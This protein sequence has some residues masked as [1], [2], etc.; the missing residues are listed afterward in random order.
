MR[1]TYD[2][3][4][5]S[6]NDRIE[7]I[8]FFNCPDCGVKHSTETAVIRSIQ[9]KSKYLRTEIKGKIITRLYLDT[10]YKVRFCHK[11][12]RKRSIKTKIYYSFFLLIIP[13]VSSSIVATS[14][15]HFFGAFIGS[16][17]LSW[18]PLGLTNLIIMGTEIDIDHAAQ[19][20]A[21]ESNKIL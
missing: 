16:F 6:I 12:A 15:G 21:L 18:V 8:K 9:T 17:F 20:N 5:D 10:Y 4:F 19:C 7:K 11:C 13:L 1:S 14:I 3:I 2:N